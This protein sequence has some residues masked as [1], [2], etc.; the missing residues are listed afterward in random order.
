MSVMVA[1]TFN[2]STQETGLCGLE[3]SMVYRVARFQASLGDVALRLVKQ[4]YLK[5]HCSIYICFS[6]YLFLF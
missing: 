5:S 3:A 6:M 1:Y 2:H 4:N